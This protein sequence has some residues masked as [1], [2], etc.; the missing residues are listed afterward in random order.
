VLERVAGYLVALSDYAAHYIGVGRL[1]DVTKVK[2]VDEEGR[3]GPVAGQQVQQLAGVNVW[4]IVKRDGH[5]AGRVAPRYGHSVRY[6]AKLRPWHVEDAAAA[7]AGIRISPA[8]A[9]THI[10]RLVKAGLERCTQ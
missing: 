2:A 8:S 5:R 9:Y 1:P 6:R 3:L 10:H 7:T 4:A